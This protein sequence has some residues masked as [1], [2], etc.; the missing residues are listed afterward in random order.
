MASTKVLEELHTALLIYL[1]KQRLEDTSTLQ[2]KVACLFCAGTGSVS[3][4]V[5][6]IAD[7]F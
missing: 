4:T 6:V 1:N 7:P 2:E 3:N 5:T